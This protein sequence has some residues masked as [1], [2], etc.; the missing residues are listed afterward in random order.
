MSPEKPRHGQAHVY[1]WSS[2]KKCPWPSVNVILLT[3]LWSRTIIRWIFYLLGRMSNISFYFFPYS[4]FKLSH[5]WTRSKLRPDGI[6][7]FIMQWPNC[8]LILP[9]WFT[10]SGIS[11]VANSRN[12]R[13]WGFTTPS[14]NTDWLIS[15]F[16][17]LL[18]QA[19]RWSHRSIIFW[20]LEVFHRRHACLYLPIH[21]QGICT[22]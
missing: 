1:T 9:N 15:Q 12:W 17:Q 16:L 2:L 6:F 8:Y 3:C 21:P 4:S 10:V 18:S 22:F 14:Q 19:Q 20:A 13:I 5:L 7:L 11:S